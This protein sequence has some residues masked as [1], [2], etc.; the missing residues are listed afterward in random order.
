MRPGTHR[1]QKPYALRIAFM[2]FELCNQTGN[3]SSLGLL[4]SSFEATTNEIPTLMIM[5]QNTRSIIICMILAKQQ[6]QLQNK[7]IP[8]INFALLLSLPSLI[9]ET[10]LMQSSSTLHRGIDERVTWS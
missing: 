1:D 4:K 10:L 3:A 6:Q 2:E 8:L 7:T 9:C 5:H